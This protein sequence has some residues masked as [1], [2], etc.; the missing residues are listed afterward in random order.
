MG[1][2]S[3]VGR[4]LGHVNDAPLKVDGSTTAPPQ[5][6]L[7]VPLTESLADVSPKALWA[8]ET[9]RAEGRRRL[10]LVKVTVARSSFGRRP[11]EGRASSIVTTR[12]GARPVA[13]RAAGRTLR[14]LGI[15]FSRGCR[16]PLTWTSKSYEANVVVGLRRVGR[17][18]NPLKKRDSRGCPLAICAASWNVRGGTTCPTTGILVAEA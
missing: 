9:R 11:D 13:F 15:P 7:T 17:D 1:V 10:R 5:A 4:W 16:Q 14:P 18:T 12:I 2:S 3:S 6:R 8:G